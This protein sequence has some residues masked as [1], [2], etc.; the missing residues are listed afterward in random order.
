MY[1]DTVLVIWFI[2]FFL[3]FS[4]QWVESHCEQI[5]NCSGRLYFWGRLSAEYNNIPC[6]T[7]LKEGKALP[8]RFSQMLLRVN[9]SWDLGIF[10]FFL[11]SERRVALIDRGL[12]SSP[13]TDSDLLGNSSIF[14]SPN[15]SLSILSLFPCPATAILHSTN[16]QSNSRKS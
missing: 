8:W 7:E 1:Y 3:S 10:N 4:K 16:I 6:E 9:D 11:V 14:F 12:S 13:P 2:V 15:H 5:N